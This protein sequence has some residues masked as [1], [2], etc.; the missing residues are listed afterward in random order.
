M[1]GSLTIGRY[2]GQA[3]LYTF[4][5]KEC[6]QRGRSI[7]RSFRCHPILCPRHR[8]HRGKMSRTGPGHNEAQSNNPQHHNTAQ[9]G[10]RLSPGQKHSTGYASVVWLW[11]RQWH[12]NRLVWPV[13]STRK[14]VFEKRERQNS[15]TRSKGMHPEGRHRPWRK[16]EEL[17]C[18]SFLNHGRSRDRFR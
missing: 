17:S 13:H 7:L 16:G 1:A 8:R 11:K 6:I 9:Q 4:A 2:S 18:V 5:Q 3:R 15:R 12:Q 14:K 10:H